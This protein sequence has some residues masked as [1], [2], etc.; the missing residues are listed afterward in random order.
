YAGMLEEKNAWP[1]VLDRIN[2]PR[3]NMLRDRVLARRHRG[4]PLVLACVD[5]VSG[6]FRN[7][8]K[9]LAML[10]GLDADVIDLGRDVRAEKVPDMLPLFNAAD[11]LVTID[12]LPLH[13]ARAATCPVVALINDGWMGTSCPPPQTVN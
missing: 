3:A 8:V 10:R 2:E 11:C 7:G 9:L 6:P 4:R 13:L 12:T 1:L 5:G